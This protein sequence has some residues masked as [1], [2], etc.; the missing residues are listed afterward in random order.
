MNE[1]LPPCTHACPVKTDVRGYL[2][3]VVRRDYSEAYRLIRA[4]NPFPT[5]CAWVCP[6]PCED[7]CR[8]GDVDASLSIRNLKRFVVEIAGTNYVETT[9]ARHTGKNIAIVGAGP[10]GLT[11]A[12][13][14][15]KLGHTVVVYERN[16][17]PGGHFLTSLPAY[18]LPREKLQMDVEAILAAGVTIQTGVEVGTGITVKELRE[19]YDAVIIAA[20]LQVSKGL[21]LPGADH[22]DVLKA[23]PFM[24]QVN[25]GEKPAVGRRVLVIGGGD[26]AMDV[27]RAAV[28]LGAEQ[29]TAM[30]LESRE[31]MPAHTWE[32][33]EAL[34]EGVSLVN[35]YGPVEVIIE[36]GRITGLKAQKVKAVFDHTGRFNPAYEP[37]AY[38]IQHCDTV[39]VAVGQ[40]PG[41]EFMND[42]GLELDA[43]GLVITDETFL[44]TSVEGVFTCGEVVTG[45]GLAIAAVASGH[46]AARAVNQYLNGSKWV[47]PEVIQDA[48]GELP[49]AV[50][51]RVPRQT[52]REMQVLPASSRIENF[53]PY[54]LGFDEETA[55]S[56]AGRCLSCGLG[57]QVAEGKC[58][59]CLTCKRVCPYE[60]PLVGNLARMPLEACQACGICAAYCPAG[61]ITIGNLNEQKIQEALAGLQGKQTLVIFAGQENSIDV[62]KLSNL[63]VITIMMPAA[64]A[65]RQEWV[66]SAFENGAAGVM[67]L[68]SRETSSRHYG[69]DGALQGMLARTKELM[70]DIGLSPERLYY[71]LPEESC[72]VVILLEKFCQKLQLNLI[73]GVEQHD[74][75]PAKEY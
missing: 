36:N 66:L 44:N 37:D 72:D 68:G 6:H 26:V 21:P 15:A 27:A 71:C 1:L 11:A 61:A 34:E 22:P 60:V 51:G 30:C 62:L 18:R 69:G 2:A 50:A 4:N 63:N 14:L 73:K 24:R 9:C 49:S 23:L 42:S 39:I 8:R 17:A 58:A 48:I 3:A 45:P 52:R 70:A 64:G 31:V 19:A 47:T 75:S 67:V 59:A 38:K 40:G 10:A 16:N 20:G 7:H 28:R 32:V 53:A 29:V 12:Y 35:G 25:L 33:E 74:H 43:R 5:V 46:R 55:I 13:D 56:E 41:Y 54:E 57:A 65:L